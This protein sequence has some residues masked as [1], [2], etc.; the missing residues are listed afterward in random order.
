MAPPPPMTSHLSR[1]PSISCPSWRQ[2]VMKFFQQRIRH[3]WPPRSLSKTP[4]VNL[5]NSYRLSR[6]T[7][8]TIFERRARIQRPFSRTSNYA[9]SNR[10]SNWQKKSQKAV[11][12]RARKQTLTQGLINNK[13]RR[14]QPSETSM[15]AG[16]N[17]KKERLGILL[18]RKWLVA[19]TRRSRTIIRTKTAWPPMQTR[20]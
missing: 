18:L 12:Q 3:A 14:H 15:A 16:Y 17:Y 9:S 7:L 13:T 11:L 1:R 19:K 4:Q 10:C 6:P 8:K 5:S 20:W 2:I